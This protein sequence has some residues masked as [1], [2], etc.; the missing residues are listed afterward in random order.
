MSC[1]RC[2]QFS[3]QGGC[4][5]HRLKRG[6]V[7]FQVPPDYACR[8]EFVA[9]NHQGKPVQ[10]QGKRHWKSYM[11]SHGLTDDVSFSQKNGTLRNRAP[12]LR[13]E[14]LTQAIHKGIEL[15]IK[16]ARSK[17]YF[18]KRLTGGV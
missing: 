3:K 8:Y 13:K 6:E 18:D 17:P 7:S 14:K 15:G 9:R 4:L 11:K 5:D 16:K 10:I 2:E 1:S 12:E